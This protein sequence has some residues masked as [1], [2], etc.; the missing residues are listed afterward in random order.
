MIT[1]ADFT[2]IKDVMSVEG[3]A[4]LAKKL[5]HVDYNS[6]FSQMSQNYQVHLRKTSHLHRTDAAFYSYVK[7]YDAGEHIWRIAE[8][9]NY[10]PTQL[11]RLFLERLRGMGK[12]EISA[13]IKDRAGITDV[14]DAPGQNIPSA[15]RVLQRDP[16]RALPASRLRDEVELCLEHDELCSPCADRRRHEIGKE[17]ERILEQCLLDHDLPF[18]TEDTLRLQGFART[19]DVRLLVPFAV[20]MHV[21]NWIDS[22]AMFADRDTHEQ[23][24]QTQYRS[25]VNR[26]GS[27]L[28]IYW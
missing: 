27:G 20:D 7:R 1:E 8:S 23:Y 17:Y 2:E 28:V 19:P 12:T 9:V 11:A 5:P 10:A 25:Y 22:K 15:A 21:V 4:E 24:T 26:F 6:I 3:V 18:V 16:P 14:V 13:C